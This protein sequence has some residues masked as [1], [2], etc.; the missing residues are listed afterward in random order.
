MSECKYP[1]IPHLPANPTLE[2]QYRL[3]P[4]IVYA[5]DDEAAQKLTLICPWSARA[6]LPEEVPSPQT[7]KLPL[8]V[9]VQGSGWTQPDIDYELPQLS[10]YAHM[11]MVVATVSH[12]N[13]TEGYPF[14]A[15]LQDVKCAIRFLRKNADLYGIDPER[16]AI[17]GT[18]SGGNTAQ[19]IALTGDDPRYETKECA[20]F[21]D[22]VTAC[23]SC[24]GP[25]D[26]PALLA[27]A[28]GEIANSDI[29]DTAFASDPAT[30]MQQMQQMSPISQVNSAKSCPP[31]LLLHGTADSVVNCSQ[32]I[33]M[34]EALV[35]AGIDVT[36]YLV[37]GADHEGNFWSAGV[38][39]VIRDFL[40]R[41][42]LL[43]K[44]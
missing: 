8:L 1:E 34:Y 18:S 42:L 26:L 28:G 17:W 6:C 7:G 23:V 40:F 14:P 5:H 44:Q 2:N 10:L 16:V 19:L 37:D 30:R 35:D 22:A 39:E 32:T 11:G 38:H 15:F 4:D 3:I 25:T 36:A 41:H 29:L 12:R 43:L 9:F 31:I 24:F 13:R 33:R 27:D 20:G 21:S